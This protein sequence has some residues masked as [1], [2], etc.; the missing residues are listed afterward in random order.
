MKDHDFEKIDLKDLAHIISAALND[1][2]I[3]AILVGGACVSIYSNNRYQSYDLDFVT[4]EEMK[5]VKQVLTKLGFSQKGKYFAHKKCPYLIDF[6]NPPIAV[7]NQPIHHFEKITTENGILQLLTPTDCVKD[8]LAA[9]FH[10]NDLQSLEQA[11][12]VAKSHPIN[13]IEIQRWAEDEGHSNKFE[14]F[15]NLLSKRT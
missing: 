7:G 12:L 11:I 2:N 1:H 8:R 15:Q 6:V 10:W 4:Y 3:S 5:K 13:A 9:Y 14:E